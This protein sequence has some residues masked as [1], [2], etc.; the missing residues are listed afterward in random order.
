MKLRTCEAVPSFPTQMCLHGVDM[1]N[2]KAGRARA[3]LAAATIA[4][5]K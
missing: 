2:L 1:D 3:I 5:P 4:L